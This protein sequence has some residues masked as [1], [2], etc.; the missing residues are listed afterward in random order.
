MTESVLAGGRVLLSV[1]DGAGAREA[2]LL[3]RV[4]ELVLA[5]EPLELKQGEAGDA[6]ADAAAGEGA[7]ASPAPGDDPA[8]P[9][10]VSESTQR[11][12]MQMRAV[13]DREAARLGADG[14]EGKAAVDQVS[15]IARTLEKID[16]MERLIAQ[17]QARSA[18]R[19]LN[20]DEREQLRQTVRQLILAAAERLALERQGQDQG[21]GGDEAIGEADA[22][23]AAEEGAADREE[24]G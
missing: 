8:A 3:D 11:M 10:L 21:E 16:Q 15:L 2:A 4:V 1:E 5:L 20:P 19:T 7:D 23:E 22:G 24:A 6:A 12:L 17:D 13:L 9:T 14:T 18:Q